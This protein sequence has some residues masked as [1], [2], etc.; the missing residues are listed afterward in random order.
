MTGKPVSPGVRTAGKSSQEEA[1]CDVWNAETGERS[2][3]IDG[4]N[5]T[6]AAFDPGGER[7][8]A[9]Q[10]VWDART[11]R[12][13][14]T[15]GV[16]SAAISPDGERI[17]SL[18]DGVKILNART[19]KELMT[20]TGHSFRVYGL[21]FGPKGTLLAAFGGDSPHDFM[22]NL[23]QNA[24]GEVTVWNT[25][26]GEKVGSFR[27]HSCGVTLAVFSPDGKRIASGTSFYKGW[28]E[29]AVWEISP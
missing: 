12:Q 2:L 17:A 5:L 28:G 23:K 22:G 25:E 9:A 10:G 3:G 29:V 7:I 14:S 19:G 6:G 27:G 21:A 18:A 8:I 13:L 26:T 4:K 1:R 16:Q 24:F 11:G 20:L 15:I